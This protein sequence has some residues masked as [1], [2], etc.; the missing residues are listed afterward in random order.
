MA[1]RFYSKEEL[2]K[3]KYFIINVVSQYAKKK[4]ELNP[5]ISENID[6]PT[7]EYV[8]VLEEALK[9]FEQGKI[10]FKFESEK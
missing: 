2:L 7:S 5:E 10:D 6:L 9:D 3:N 8:Y 1:I 4:L